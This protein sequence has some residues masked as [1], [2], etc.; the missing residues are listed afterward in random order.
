[1]KKAI[2]TAIFILGMIVTAN[3][4]FKIHSDG[5]ISI[6]T[7]ATPLSPISINDAGVADYYLSYYGPK[8]FIYAGT[9]S[10]NTGSSF[11]LHPSSN[12]NFSIAL[13]AY[14]YPYYAQDPHSIGIGAVCRSEGAP[15]TIG[16]LCY[17][18]P[19]T[20]GAGLVASSTSTLPSYSLFDHSY[21][22][23]FLGD[24][25]VTSNLTVGGSIQGVLLSPPASSGGSV[26]MQEVTQE[27]G[28]DTASLLAGLDAYAYRHDVR[29]EDLEATFETIEV[30]DSLTVTLA[31]ADE[32]NYIGRQSA[33]NTHYALDAEQIEKVFPGLVYE[34][35]DG[36]KCINYVE[37]VPLLVQSI[38][39]L[40][41]RIQELEG[42]KD[43]T[44]KK[45]PSTTSVGSGFV[46]VRSAVLYQNTPNP[47]TAQTVIRFSLPDNTDNAYIYIFDMTGKMQKQIAVDSS[48]QSVTINGYELTPGIYLYS[49]VING[50][51]VDT[52]RMILSK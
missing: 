34:M 4:Q 3:A 15:Y 52:K 28:T 31:S 26:T 32:G 17:I 14:S 12:S 8:P 44:A 46:P 19:D 38:N 29:A 9:N 18:N 45:A 6:N 27:K 11:I 41:A 22:G 10:G 30:N 21:A 2:L 25:K 16:S 1:M 48:M 13:S 5:K 37:M 40:S 50:Q 33:G 43:K 24:V 23:F 35:A 39:E 49:L 42:M 20:A 36:T 7:T 47:F 51:E